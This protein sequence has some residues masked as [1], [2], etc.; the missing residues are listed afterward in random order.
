MARR[1]LDS[2]PA[3]DALAAMS[4]ELA[5]TAVQAA[6]D[7]GIAIPGDLAVSGWDDTPAEAAAGVTTIHQDL[8]DHGAHCATAATT[9]PSPSRWIE[10]PWQL[11]IR[12]TTAS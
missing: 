2:S 8:R 12:D 5:L 3:P 1:L 4:D 11:V 10:R 6:A 7:R 9:Q